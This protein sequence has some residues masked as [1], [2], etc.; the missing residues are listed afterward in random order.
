MVHFFKCI[1]KYYCIYSLIVI[2]FVVWHNYYVTSKQSYCKQYVVVKDVM[3]F[4]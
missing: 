3:G 4:S 1:M 2:V